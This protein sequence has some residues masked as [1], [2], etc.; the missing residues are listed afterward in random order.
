MR[1]VLLSTLLLLA[2]GCSSPRHA[3]ERPT[4]PQD[5]VAFG[6]V[7]WRD[8]PVLET[9]APRPDPYA[10][11]PERGGALRRH[12]PLPSGWTEAQLKEAVAAFVHDP[13]ASAEEVAASIRVRLDTVD[14]AGPAGRV[15]AIERFVRDRGRM[16]GQR[17]RLAAS[18]IQL[19]EPRHA[20]P[21]FTEVEVAPDGTA[22]AVLPASTSWPLQAGFR[23]RQLLLEVTDGAVQ[24]FKDGS[25]QELSRRSY[26]R[27]ETRQERLPQEGPLSGFAGVLRA[28]VSAGSE[29][30]A[31]LLLDAA[32]Q[33]SFVRALWSEAAV[34]G[35]WDQDRPRSAVLVSEPL[36]G[37][38]VLS[39]MEPIRNTPTER[40]PFFG[41]CRTA[42]AGKFTFRP[43]ETLCL[44]RPNGQGVLVL[45]VRWEDGQV[46]G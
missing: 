46:R 21:R 8:V 17:Y 23:G 30:S 45:L 18:L 13:D 9:A 16:N 3:W 43:G 5:G 14:I 6:E 31:T 10:A 25:H 15:A 11:D 35:P 32:H 4:E 33:R 26:D 34:P 1:A 24:R 37:G 7:P 28:V 38:E 12:A 20:L 40:L 39:Y 19:E 2:A 36:P 22:V 29:P 44:L 42:F 27:E 41:V